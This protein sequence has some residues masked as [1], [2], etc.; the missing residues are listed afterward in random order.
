MAATG[1]FLNPTIT[2]LELFVTSIPLGVAT[3]FFLKYHDD[4]YL[5]SNWHV[6]AGR[7]PLS[8]QPL[9]SGFCVPDRLRYTIYGF[10][11]DTQLAAEAIE[12]ELGCADMGTAQWFQ[13][14]SMGQDIDIGCLPL[15]DSPVGFAK[16]LLDPAAHDPDMYIDLGHEVFL[17]GFPLGFTA[18][19][20]MPIWKR[21]SVA[22]SL[23]F[24][25]GIDTCFFVDTATRS[26]MSG[27]PCLAISNWKHYRMDRSTGKVTV[28]RQPMSHRLLGVY[29]GRRNPSDGFEAQIGVVWRENRIFEILEAKVPARI[30]LRAG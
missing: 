15:N 14:P 29:S 27:A 8:G 16:N 11:N 17:P 10:I 3:G 28:V 24:G 6:F 30:Q 18:Y 21:A 1:N 26:G 5:I 20:M 2:R 23:E 13:H 25:Q 22:S 9:D 12:V 19:G 7:S 4:W